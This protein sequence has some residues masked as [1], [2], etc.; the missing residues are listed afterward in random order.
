MKNKA[1]I[2]ITVTDFSREYI[3]IHI[4]NG[5]YIAFTINDYMYT[6]KRFYRK[7]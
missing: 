2:T 7:L 4:F 5:L 3:Y 1:D 6:T